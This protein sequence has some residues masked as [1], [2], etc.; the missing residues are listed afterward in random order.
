M[1]ED[2]EKIENDINYN[3]KQIKEISSYIPFDI[4]LMERVENLIKGYRELEK[5]N[6]ELKASHVITHNKVSSEEKAK[7]FDVI[8]NSIDTYLEQTKPYWE[9]IMTKE[10]MT[11]EEA[12]RIIDDMYQDRNKIL[13]KTQET[14]TEVIFDVAKLDDVK[15]TNL[16]FAS[17]RALREIQS[18]R[19]ELK[20]SIPKSK[21]QEKIDELEKLKKE[22]EKDNNKFWHPE[23]NNIIYHIKE[24]ME[25]K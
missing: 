8:D 6:K 18:L 9:Q 7:L 22:L 25:D 12:E 3:K 1:E 5:E 19:R 21:I 10:K 4:K 13:R 15:F 16:E 11:S 17:V 24:L 2:I 23:I 14:E 20:N